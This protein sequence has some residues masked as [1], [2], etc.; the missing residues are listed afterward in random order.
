MK[1]NE[2]KKSFTSQKTQ[3]VFIT[4]TCQSILCIHII[5]DD[6]AGGGND[7]DDDDN[8]KNIYLLQL[9]CHPWQWLVCM[10][11]KYEIDYY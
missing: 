8:N 9:C 1:L 4:K 6:G 11:T 3:C 2:V 5:D 10:Y 7:D